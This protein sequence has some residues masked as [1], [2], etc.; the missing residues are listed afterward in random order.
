MRREADQEGEASLSR[1]E[2]LL[3]VSSKPVME[4]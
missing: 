2:M 4:E 3:Q 1:T